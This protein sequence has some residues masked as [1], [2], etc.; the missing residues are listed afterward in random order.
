MGDTLKDRVAIITGSGQGIGRAIA[1]AMASEG[2]KVMTNNRWPGTPGGDAES[3]AKEIKEIGGQ[4]LP[5]F[6][7]VSSFTK[8]EELIKKTENEFGRLDILVNNAGAVAASPL[9]EMSEKDWN[10]VLDSHL[11]GTFNCTRHACTLMI[12]QGWG[13]VLNVTSVLRFG[14]QGHC[15]Y[16]AAKAG[17]V[18]LT[19]AMAMELGEYGI[20]CNVFSP[21]ATTRQNQS[22]GVRVRR[23]RMFEAG[24]MNRKRYEELTNASSPDVIPPLLIYIC[25]DEAASINGIVFH[26][27]DGEIA[28]STETEATNA[29]HKAG[30]LWTIEELIKLI[31]T[32]V[33]IPDTE[34]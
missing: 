26:I 24:L 33:L 21:I 30:G 19:R 6:G 13:R 16:S 28:V 23:Q 22:E 27:A 17:I 20:T 7:D 12:Q 34:S 31:P 9:W 1:L 15:S 32:E 4:A 25:T 29:I 11:K 3:T 8:A 2:A 14:I 10:T 18:G 5:F